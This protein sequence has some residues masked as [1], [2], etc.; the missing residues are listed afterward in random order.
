[1]IGSLIDLVNSCESRAATVLSCNDTKHAETFQVTGECDSARTELEDNAVRSTLG[2]EDAGAAKTKSTSNKEV[3]DRFSSAGIS[4]IAT[5][6]SPRITIVTYTLIVIYTNSRLE[7]LSMYIW[8]PGWIT[9][10]H[11][12][13]CSRSRTQKLNNIVARPSTAAIARPHIHS[14]CIRPRVPLNCL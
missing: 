8:Y 12:R 14:I 3:S 2:P 7:R 5:H 4:E 13:L 6:P 9:L 1:M 11:A 10:Y